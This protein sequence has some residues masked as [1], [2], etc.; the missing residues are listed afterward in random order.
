MQKYAKVCKVCKT[1]KTIK[2]YIFNFGMRSHPQ[3]R[4][5][6]LIT[7]ASPHAPFR[8][9]LSGL[10]WVGCRS[11]GLTVGR[12]PAFCQI[13]HSNPTQTCCGLDDGAYVIPKCL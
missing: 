5:P 3:F 9:A 8:A 12:F 4:A 11:P 7:N 10:L 13:N 6:T 1:T 2:V